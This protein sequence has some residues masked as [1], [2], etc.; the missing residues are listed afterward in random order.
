VGD[1]GRLD[2]YKQYR[3]ELQS[4]RQSNVDQLDGT[5]LTLS[6]G[7]LGLSLAFMKDVVPL[8]QIALLGV[9]YC[10]WVLFVTAI[11]LVL[12][13]FATNRMAID[14][15]LVI[16]DE[17][18]LERKSDAYNKPN[19]WAT[20]TEYLSIGSIAAFVLAI[21]LTVCFVSINI[22]SAAR[23][24]HNHGGKNVIPS[25][26]SDALE[27]KGRPSRMPKLPDETTHDPG[28]PAT[29]TPPPAE[30]TVP[31]TG[32]KGTNKPN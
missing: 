27:T 1:Q 21:I 8:A 9:L 10:S 26:N 29:G 28:K 18:F 5:I 19:P 23:S 32:T 31:P 25:S 20:V 2:L 7:G 15:Q 13:S 30:K 4:A 22:S 12:L 24:P 6:G 11:L 17:Y 3:S 16:A 14:A